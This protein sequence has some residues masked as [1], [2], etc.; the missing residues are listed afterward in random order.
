LTTEAN[1][2]R[3]YIDTKFK[4]L[5][6][7]AIFVLGDMNDGPGKEY[8]ESMYL[9]FDLINNIQG[10]IFKAS[11]FLNHGLFDYSENLRWS[12]QVK[13][14]VTNKDEK[15]LIDH[16]LFTQ[17][18]V[19]W[20]LPLVCVEPNAGK[21]EHEIHDLINSRLNKNQKTSDHKPV[22]LEIS[23]KNESDPFKE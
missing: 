23:Y 1:Q 4:Q 14:F 6:N 3:S 13:D 7:P 21:V 15:I 18:L 8:F 20:K 9:H 2:I 16:I 10:D 12:Y 22:S 17:A 11:Q 5:E 19:N